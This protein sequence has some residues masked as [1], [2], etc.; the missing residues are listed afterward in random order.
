MGGLNADCVRHLA[1]WKGLLLLS[2]CLLGA[3]LFVASFI[4]QERF[5]YYWDYANYWLKFRHLGALL[6]TSPVEALQAVHA[7]VREDD[8]NLLLALFLAPF[9]LV[10]GGGR[11]AYELAIANF[12]VVPAAAAA[13]LLV[14]RLNTSSQASPDLALGLSMAGFLLL[15]G[16]WIPALYGAPDLA[17]MVLIGVVLLLHLSRPLGERGMAGLLAI[18]VSLAALI[19]L[20]R[21]YAYWVVGYFVAAVVQSLVQGGGRRPASLRAYLRPIASLVGI[22]VV[23]V[24]FL[25]L[26]A[27]PI[28]NRMAASDYADMYSAY[29]VAGEPL[30]NFV[31]FFVRY[32]GPLTSVLFV[33]GLLFGLV[34]ASSRSFFVFLLVQFAVIVFMFTRVQDMSAHHYNLLI[35]TIALAVSSLLVGVAVRFRAGWPRRGV[36][37][38]Y[39]AVL[40]VQFALVFVPA[41]AHHLAW[42]APFLAQYR[43]APLARN[44]LGAMAELLAGL[45]ARLAGNDRKVYVLASSTVI[46]D[47][48]LRNACVQFE[49]PESACRRILDASHVDK[50]DGFP[51]HLP[52]A[53]YVVVA[54]PVQYH[55]RPEDQLVIGL[56]AL[57][58]LSG[59]GLGAAFGRLPGDYMLDKGVT[60][61]IYER[62]RPLVAGDLADIESRLLNAYPDKS[63][64]F[65]L[66]P[67]GLPH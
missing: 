32:F 40:A 58:M 3:N 34:R 67:G 37:A 10:F 54:E 49:Y 16:V 66:P 12:Y 6:S 29:K 26:V 62:I 27:T 19:L 51:R 42:A 38:T 5:I 18:G 7:S 1:S 4:G 41:A 20:R 53:D 8:Y 47:D 56:P 2:F 33:A 35:P 63:E 39:F 21:W 25:F 30:W 9:H 44:D 36:V 61:S 22:G 60:V 45:N 48:I 43:H 57:A 65:S 11:L 46:N 52:M 24:G 50:R 59:Q 17:G 13:G 28:A 14:C 15:P 31:R 64:L 55:L 23:A